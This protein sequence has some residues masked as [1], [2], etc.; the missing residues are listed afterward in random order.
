MCRIDRLDLQWTTNPKRLASNGHVDIPLGAPHQSGTKREYERHR[1]LEVN[2]PVYGLEAAIQR[3]S[4][5][6]E[7]ILAKYDG[8]PLPDTPSTLWANNSY[9]SNFGI[10]PP[11][12]NLLN[13]FLTSSAASIP[14]RSMENARRAFE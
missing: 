13:G 7:L 8:T 10:S 3:W 1:Y 9:L 4:R 11:K 6:E 5:Y 14:T 2:D 12:T